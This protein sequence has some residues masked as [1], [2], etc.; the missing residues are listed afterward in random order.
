MDIEVTEFWIRVKDVNEAQQFVEKLDD[1]CK[2]TAGD[3][4]NYG[5]NYG[6]KK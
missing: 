5:F 6:E 4:K 3:V 1:L 2:Q